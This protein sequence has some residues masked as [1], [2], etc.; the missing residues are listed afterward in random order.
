[1]R[2]SGKSTL[3]ERM[4]MLPIFPRGEGT[5]TRLP[6][7][8]ELRNEAAPCLPKLVVRLEKSAKSEREQ[9]ITMEKGEASVRNAMDEVLKLEKVGHSQRVASACSA[10]GRV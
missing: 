9:T 5:C 8:I 2:S 7:H 6:V 4:T 10:C 1:M 3:L